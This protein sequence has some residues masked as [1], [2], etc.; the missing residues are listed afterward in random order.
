MRASFNYALVGLLVAAVSA[1]S[2]NDSPTGPGNVG[3]DSSTETE[4]EVGSKDNPEASDPGNPDA[5]TSHGGEARDYVSLIDNLRQVGMT[6]EPAGEI[7][8]PFFSVQ[9]YVIKVY[10]E[11][12]QVFEFEDA[13]TASSEA[14]LVSPDGS[15]IGTSMVSWMAAPHFYQIER[16]IVLYVGEEEAVLQALETVLGSP[17]VGQTPDSSESAIGVDGGQSIAPDVSDGIETGGEQGKDDGNVDSIGTDDE[18]GDI[19]S[20]DIGRIEDVGDHGEGSGEEAPEP[21]APPTVE[22]DPHEPTVESI[23]T[24][25]P[26]VEG[27]PGEE[28]P[29]DM[30]VEHVGTEMPAVEGTPGEIDPESVVIHLPEGAEQDEDAEQDD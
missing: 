28:D 7:D 26:A 11:D 1:C 20:V 9:A 4:F 25:M 10:G 24:G 21:V 16:L 22:E 2:G 5:I 6:V 17:F 29:Q 23:S 12:V 30:V 3:D 18:T 15:S 19:H 27:M 14:K 8:Q 13:E